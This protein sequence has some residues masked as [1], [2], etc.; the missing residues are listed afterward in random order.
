M[1]E[2]TRHATVAVEGEMSARVESDTWRLR[3]EQVRKECMD[4]IVLAFKQHVG[5]VSA[6]CIRRALLLSP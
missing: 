4:L 6:A 3:C 2:E 5:H 1:L